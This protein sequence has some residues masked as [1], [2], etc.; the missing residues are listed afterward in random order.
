MIFNNHYVPK[1]IKQEIDAKMPDFLSHIINIVIFNYPNN[2]KEIWRKSLYNYF[3]NLDSLSKIKVKNKYILLDNLSNYVKLNYL[4][5]IQNYVTQISEEALSRN[6]KTPINKTINQD[7][8]KVIEDFVYSILKDVV[9]NNINKSMMLT[10]QDVY[11]KLKYY[12]I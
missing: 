7:K 4:D 10:Q 3:N 6:P 1:I 9:E 2:I 12:N 8:I 11:I 5:F